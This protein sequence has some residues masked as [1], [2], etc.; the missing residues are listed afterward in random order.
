MEWNKR[1]REI[2]HEME[3]E[4]EGENEWNGRRE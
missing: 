4:S 3:E 1:V 2:I